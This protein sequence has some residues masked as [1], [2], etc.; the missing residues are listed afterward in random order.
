M[1]PLLAAVAFQG[2]AADAV[3]PFEEPDESEL[4]RFE[5]QLVTVASRYA[6]T[7][8]KAPSIVTLITADEIR[9]R[10][11]RN[12]SEALRT[13]PGFYVWRSNEGRDLAAIRGVISAD[14]NKLL[15]L[16]DGVP[17][18]EGVYTH[19][20]IDDYLPISN[21]KQIEVI[22]GPG[23]AIYGTNAFTGVINIV[24]WRPSD[25][26]GAK[27]RVMAGS[28]TRGDVTVSAGGRSRVG[29]L[30]TTA[31]A[32]ARL[33]GQTGQGIDV[34]PDLDIDVPGTD[35]RKGVAAG[36]E[37][38]VEGL[39]LQLHHVDYAHT[40]LINGRE[41]PFQALGRQLDTFDLEYHDTFV[42]ARYTLST[43]AVDVTPYAFYQ[44][45]DNPGA[46]FF[47]GD[48]TV[49]PDTLEASQFF[50]TVDAEKTTERSGGGLDV[51]ARPALDHVIVGGLGIEGVR[52]VRLFDYGIPMDGE[53]SVLNG[54]TVIDDCGQ[55]TGL[56]TN[57]ETC[58]KPRLRNL[59]GYVQYTWT[60]APSLE[61]TGGAR[62]DK[63]IPTNEGEQGD[64]GA[65]VL[66][67][68][69]RA[70]VLLVPSDDVTVKLL[71]GRA[72]RAPNVR[73][74]LVRSVPDEVTGEYQF[75]SGNLALIPETIHTT[76]GEVTAAVA[77]GVELRADA[78]WSLLVNE[79]DKIS[80]GLYCNLPGD[81]S[82]LGGEAG[83]KVK[84]GP[85]TMQADYALTLATYG[86][87]TQ[88]DRSICDLDWT[89]P[90]GGR[91]QY[92]YPPHM[93]K[94]S[95]RLAISPRLSVTAFGE[96]YSARPRREWSP[97]AKN[98]DGDAFG[99]LHLAGRAAGLGPKG[100]AEIGFAVRNVLDTAWNTGVYRDDADEDDIPGGIAGEGRSVL[101]SLEVAL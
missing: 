9:E 61:L 81:L 50:M 74:L 47:G 2:L 28:T 98:P 70:G 51:Q 41:D 87:E 89:N 40:Y 7:V 85:A 96:V 63:R 24:T 86:D 64:D 20:F 26:E 76:E 14:D 13:L 62:V 4:F 93:G 39:Q 32:Y 27:V 11:Y 8:R 37:L 97:N 84:A 1:S 3:N 22:K 90:Y 56:Y 55:A 58:A 5:E 69:P 21:I 99:L 33:F 68:S 79:I 45:H 38:G 92:E 100:N 48:I 71:Y 52:V 29:R 59:F 30:D 82:I 73:E 17:W 88:L 36:V 25:L 53:P 101:V 54:F 49:D 91:R 31:T 44:R 77:E 10:G 66:A 16:V 23:S 95:V 57:T 83:A 80:P 67:V 43:T 35:P 46:Y 42:D 6:Q 60:A 12:V 78:S 75:A 34:Q 19:G 65:F 15:V 18:Y 72:F 94:G